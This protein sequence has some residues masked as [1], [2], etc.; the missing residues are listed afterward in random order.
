LIDKSIKRSVPL[1]GVPLIGTSPV[2]LFFN[3]NKLLAERRLICY[4]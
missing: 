4:K 3:I 2:V 1:I